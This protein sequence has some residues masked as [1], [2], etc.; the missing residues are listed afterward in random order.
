MRL[1]SAQLLC[2]VACRGNFSHK[3]LAAVMTLI[4]TPD[5]NSR[6]QRQPSKL[7]AQL[8]EGETLIY[9]GVGMQIQRRQRLPVPLTA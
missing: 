7:V 2:D 4:I 9:E 6:S 5:H 1:H 3:H 8:F